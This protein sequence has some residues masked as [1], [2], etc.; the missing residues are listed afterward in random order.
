MMAQQQAE[1]PAGGNGHRGCT[2]GL[3]K[4]AVTLAILAVVTAILW[5]AKTAAVGPH[6]PVFFYL[7][8]VA[9]VAILYGSVAATSCTVAA[10]LC[11]AFFLYD[12]VFS[13]AVAN[14]LEYGDLICFIALA[15]MAIKCTA[16]LLRPSAA[17]PAATRPVAARPAAAKPRYGRL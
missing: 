5:S 12:P 13:F 15:L 6:H 7:L 2:M 9:L 10:A 1:L 11:S 14:P 4:G 3:V 8:P 16:E 17:T